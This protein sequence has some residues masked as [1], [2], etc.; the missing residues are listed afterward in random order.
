M[1]LQEPHGV[2]AKPPPDHQGSPADA[3]RSWRAA[4]TDWRRRV[5]V[6]PAVGHQPKRVYVDLSHL[7]GVAVTKFHPIQTDPP[8]THSLFALSN[9]AEATQAFTRVSLGL[10]EKTDAL[11]AQLEV[12]GI[13]STKAHLLAAALRSRPV[14]V[15]SEDLSLFDDVDVLS[16]RLDAKLHGLSRCV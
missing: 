3:G 5:T 6:M 10:A 4:A 8:L 15:A 7:P 2:P 1:S 16:K 14:L 11:A 9:N 13:D 12:A